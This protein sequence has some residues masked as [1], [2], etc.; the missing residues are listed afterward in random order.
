[1]KPAARVVVDF[2]RDRRRESDDVVIKNFLEFA[3]PCDEA[4]QIGEPFLAAGFYLRKIP[5]RNNFLLH[6]RLA[7]QELDL[8]PDAELVFIRPDRPHFRAR[9]ARYH[10]GRIMES[11]HR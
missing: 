4:G 7:G 2:F 5:G 3:L 8:Q 11:L 10:A 6:Q 9:V 1:M